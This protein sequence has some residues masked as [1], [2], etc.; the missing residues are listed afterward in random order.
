MQH[1]QLPAGMQDSHIETEIYAQVTRDFPSMTEALC[2]DFFEAPHKQ[3]GYSDIFFVA[4][5][6]EYLWQYV[7]CVNAAGLKVKIVDIDIYALKRAVSFVLTPL[8]ATNEAQAM[9]CAMNNIA[10]FIVFNGR[11]ILFHQ[12]WDMI[13]AIDFHS[14]LKS[15][16]QIFFAT[17]GHIIIR[18][19]AIC[20]AAHY[21]T[22]LKQVLH[23]IAEWEICYPDP[24]SQIKYG[25]AVDASLLGEN[26]VEFL[27]ACGLAMREVPRW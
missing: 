23:A 25:P 10:S 15:R 18:R 2:I 21:L 16:I 22:W 4:V 13:D 5:R 24:L 3:A 17:F 26:A 27:T 12:Q 6:Q 7:N 11:D 19:L 1:I 14:Q 9:V 20:A 8:V